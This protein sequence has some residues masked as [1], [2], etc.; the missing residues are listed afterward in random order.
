MSADLLKRNINYLLP[1]LLHI[2]NLSITSGK[3]PNS[4]KV[5]K[6]IP[7][8]GSDSGKNNYHPISL[9]VFFKVLERIVKDQGAAYGHS[10]LSV[11]QYGL[12]CDKGVFD[13][14]YDINKEI[15]DSISESLRCMV[16][17]DRLLF[18]S[19]TDFVS[20]LYQ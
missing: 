13:T 11:N 15:N 14:L 17:S 6:V 20:N 8:H 2:I 10:V 16:L 1:P 5:A 9:G 7:L 12:R 19:M 4:F 3:F 18:V